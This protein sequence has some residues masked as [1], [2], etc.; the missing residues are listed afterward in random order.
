MN[1]LSLSLIQ[2]AIACK[3]CSLSKR[4]L[5]K[6]ECQNQAVAFLQEHIDIVLSAMMR[7]GLCECVFENETDRVLGLSRSCLLCESARPL[8]HEDVVELVKEKKERRSV[9]RKLDEAEK[10]NVVPFILRK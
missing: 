6:S 4:R 2:A 3:K 9:R 10:R 7:G 8:I 1:A 5:E